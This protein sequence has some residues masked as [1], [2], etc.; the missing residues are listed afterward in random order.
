MRKKR[1]KKGTITRWNFVK[2]EEPA[3]FCQIFPP[4]F[5]IY[6][7]REKR[8]WGTLEKQDFRKLLESMYELYEQGMYRSDYGIPNNREQAEDAVQDSFEKL[9]KYLPRID[10]PDSP[11]TRQ[12]VLKIVRNTA[13]DQHRRNHRQNQ[14]MSE[15]KEQEIDT[16]TFI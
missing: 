16:C 3:C 1:K 11:N 15:Q 14:W 7:E 6:Y 12:L 4:V 9:L 10:R 8:R 5:V 2:N 13:I